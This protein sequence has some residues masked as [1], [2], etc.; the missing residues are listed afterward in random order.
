MSI[1]GRGMKVKMVLA[2]MAAGLLL[3]AGSCQS[4]Q[5]DEC[6]W[7]LENSSYAVKGGGGDKGGG[8]RGFSKTRPGGGVSKPKPKPQKP[9]T[10]PHGKVWK[11]DCD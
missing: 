8:D 4:T 6:E 11:W 7:D 2:A 3:T 1:T 10:A 9:H 5:S